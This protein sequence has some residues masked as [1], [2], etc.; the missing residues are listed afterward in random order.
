MNSDGTW[1]VSVRFYEDVKLKQALGVLDERG[2]RVPERGRLQFNEQL[3]V[4]ATHQQVLSL[5]ED[6]AVRSIEQALPPPEP[7][8]LTSQQISNVDDIQAA[9]FNL[10]GTGVILGIWDG[11][12]VRA[13]HPDLTPRVTVIENDQGAS[14][15]GTHV[16]GTMISSGANNATAEGMAPAA[17]Q[18]FSFD[19]GDNTTTEQNNAVTNNNI[20]IANHSWGTVIG[21][22]GN[23][24]VQSGNQNLFGSYNGL[25]QDWDD[26]VQTTG[27]VVVKSSGND[28]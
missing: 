8:N 13:N 23:P 17:G 12:P 20:V 15:H 19:F 11:G 18:L 28:R 7:H 6:P 2:V 24:P 22:N 5:S 9:P 10:N 3:A 4:A 16:A 27:L 25:A 1:S 21:W 14:G 26:L